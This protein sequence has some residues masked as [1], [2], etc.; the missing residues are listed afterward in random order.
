[1]KLCILYVYIYYNDM[2]SLK[3]TCGWLDCLD[4]GDKIS[5]SDCFL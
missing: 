5:T 1:M 2:G 3:C 4:F